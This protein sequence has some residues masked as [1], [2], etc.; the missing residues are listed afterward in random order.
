MHLK[1]Y[2]L[3]STIAGPLIDLYLRY[4]KK[5]GKEDP[6]R[7]NERLGHASF[8]RPSGSLI[9]VHAASIGEVISVLPMIEKIVTKYSDINVLIT[10]GTVT[11]AKMLENK[12]PERTFHQYVPIDRLITVNRFLDHWKPDLALWTES[13]LW[14]NMIIETN[15]RG[16][17]M[18]QVNGRISINSFEKWARY[19]KMADNILSCFSLSLEIGRAHV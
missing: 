3:L 5:I 15:R 2:R 17:T 13:E 12:M 19:S 11:S 16:C 6:K 7:F 8:P 1:L 10:T 18:I 14:P 4:R 9:W